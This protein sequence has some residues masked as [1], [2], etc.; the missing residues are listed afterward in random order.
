M[1]FVSAL[2]A[3]LFLPLQLEWYKAPF[4]RKWLIP[5]FFIGLAYGMGLFYL[6]LLDQ[7]ISAIIVSY[8]PIIGIGL[9]IDNSL[10]FSIKKTFRKRPALVGAGTGFILLLAFA[11]FWIMQPLFLA[12]AKFNI[13]GGE[14][15]TVE[16]LSPVNE[17]NIPVV[18]PNFARYRS[19]ILMGQLDNPAFYDLGK[20]RI[21]RVNDSLYWITP[22]EYDGFFRWYR[23]NAAPGYI[24][25]SAENPREEPELVLTDMIYV[26]SGFFHENLERHVRMA[27]PDV[28]MLDTTFEIDG[29]GN[30]YY[31]VSYGHYT[32]FRR[33]AEVDGIIIVDPQTGDMEQYA[34]EDAPEWVNRI[35]PPHIAAERNLW[36]GIYKQG[37][38]NRFFGREGLTEPTQWGIED[39]VVGVVNR[40]LQL[41][42]F[43]DH[44]RLQ[45]EGTI[46]QSMVGFTTFDARTGE[47]HYFRDASGMLNGRTAMNLAERTFVRDDYVA[48]TPSLYNI[49]GQY[50]W[51]VP[52][53][54]RNSVLRQI[55]LVNGSSESVFGHGET[56]R[57]A[58]SAYQLALS[59]RVDENVVPGEITDLVEITATVERVY[60]WDRED[61]VTVRLL[62][63]GYDRIFTVN[64]SAYPRAVFIEPGDEITISF[65]DTG[66]EVQAIE[67]LDF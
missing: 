2:L 47:L 54:D 11:L 43:T 25:V 57:E 30:P 58:F 1:I 26:P 17:Q 34:K 9:M 63:E 66:E 41:S 42:W 55:M 53:M 46:S 13:A 10:V 3:L 23:S 33:V 21:Q 35:Y 29:E 16:E 59:T 61:N 19:D 6:G 40:E 52:L 50:T 28:L 4:F 39:S 5:R 67:E 62:I 56:K 18:P 48:G 12:D 37:I 20:T 14:E 36:F 64:A 51:V 38:V 8:L 15:V 45:G 49:Y 60:K 32:E 24:M 65:M 44:M 27:F 31:I 7:S 22:I